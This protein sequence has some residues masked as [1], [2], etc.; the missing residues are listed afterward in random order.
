VGAS[1]K[2]KE[3]ND[4]R[5]E[6]E[7]PSV[8]PK[9]FSFLSLFPPSL[10]LSS[11]GKNSGKRALRSS[12]EEQ[13]AGSRWLVGGKQKKHEVEKQGKKGKREREGE[14]F[15][16]LSPSLFLPRFCLPHSDD[17]RISSTYS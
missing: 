5:K 14:T 13:G 10:S 8:S 11:S 17:A 6:E 2:E 16:L 4:E 9:P 7:K 12:R 1:S 15:V 3:K